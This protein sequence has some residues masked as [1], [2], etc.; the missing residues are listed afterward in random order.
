MSKKK[1]QKI[2]GTIL[3]LAGAVILFGIPFYFILVNVHTYLSG[4]LFCFLFM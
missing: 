4:F 2:A 1:I 3:G